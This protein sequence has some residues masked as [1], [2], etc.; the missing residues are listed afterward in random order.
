MWFSLEVFLLIKYFRYTKLKM[1]MW[2]C[3]EFLIFFKCS[4]T[5]TCFSECRN[6]LSTTSRS[7]DGCNIFILCFRYH[8]PSLRKCSAAKKVQIE[9]YTRWNCHV[10]TQQ[11]SGKCQPVLREMVASQL[12]NSSFALWHSN[13]PWITFSATPQG[14][15]ECS[16]LG[17]GGGGGCL[18]RWVMGEGLEGD[19]GFKK[20]IFLRWVTAE[21]SVGG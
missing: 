18:W 14:N 21:D 4:L 11:G 3:D 6:W 1:F 5:P 20:L 13:F 10:F 17:E 7:T 15:W 8:M 19:N 9:I 2:H 12:R 16:V